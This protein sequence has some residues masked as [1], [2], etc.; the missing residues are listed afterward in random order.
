IYKMK[1]TKTLWNSLDDELTIREE[2][3][4]LGG[5]DI[6]DDDESGNENTYKIDED[7]ECIVGKIMTIGGVPDISRTYKNKY[8]IMEHPKMFKVTI[9]E[10]LEE[11]EKIGGQEFIDAREKERKNN[12]KCIDVNFTAIHTMRLL[13]EVSERKTYGIIKTY[14]KDTK[15]KNIKGLDNYWE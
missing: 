4:E 10:D 9:R 15:G 5:G 7:L 12:E 1:I 13:K 2:F 6:K 3:G 11:I 14:T 8:G